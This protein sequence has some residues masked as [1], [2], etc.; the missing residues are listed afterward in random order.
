MRDYPR[1]DA[2]IH[3]TDIGLSYLIF[4]TI[5]RDGDSPLLQMKKRSERQNILPELLQQGSGQAGTGIPHIKFSKSAT[6]IP[7]TMSPVLPTRGKQCRHKSV[8]LKFSP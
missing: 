8:S 6:P 2:G 1:P 3:W 4:T 5:L 7:G